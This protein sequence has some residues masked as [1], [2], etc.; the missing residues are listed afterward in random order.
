MIKVN[1]KAIGMIFIVLVLALAGLLIKQAI[2]INNLQASL[3]KEVA[4]NDPSQLSDHQREIWLAVLEWCESRGIPNIKT[5]DSNSKYSYGA[6]QFQMA[7]FLDYGKKYNLIPASTTPA[8]GKLLIFDYELQKK[9]A[10]KMLE[11]SLESH[12]R[13]CYRKIGEPYPKD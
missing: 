13:V 6:F 1:N 12:W 4:K 3:V 7:T 11:D 8:Q 10:T 2:T 9:L 5:L